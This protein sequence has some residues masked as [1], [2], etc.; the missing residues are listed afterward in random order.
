MK[1]KLVLVCLVLISAFS[2]VRVFSRDATDRIE[3]FILKAHEDKVFNGVILVGEKGEQ[4]D[5]RVR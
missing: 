5:R 2:P 1:Y 3:R 4:A